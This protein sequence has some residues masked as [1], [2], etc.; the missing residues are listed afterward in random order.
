MT[1]SAQ[2]AAAFGSPASVLRARRLGR[3]LVASPQGP[4]VAFRGP[5]RAR[6][7][8]AGPFRRLAADL[9]FPGA[10]GITGTGCE[11]VLGPLIKGATRE[12][13]TAGDRPGG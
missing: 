1:A 8:T 11:R 7:A 4:R 2:H 9:R 5:L 12:Q 10:F 6:S 13:S 3:S